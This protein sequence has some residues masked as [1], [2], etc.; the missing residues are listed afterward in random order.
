LW[1]KEERKEK[2]KN[3]KVKPGPAKRPT[4]NKELLWEKST[5]GT[6]VKVEATAT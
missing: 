5:K 1:A 2:T 6:G 3:K 4:K